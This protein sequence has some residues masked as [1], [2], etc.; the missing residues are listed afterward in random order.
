M[1]TSDEAIK[2]LDEVEQNKKK[3]LKLKQNK[4]GLT[5]EKRAARIVIVEQRK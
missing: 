1:I 5:N 4:K 2:I 3:I